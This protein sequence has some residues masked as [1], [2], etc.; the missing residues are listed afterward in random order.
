MSGKTI[1][2]IGHSTHPLEEFISMLQSFQVE[3]VADIRR[4]PG[5]KRYPYFNT[6]ALRVSLPAEGIGYTHLEDLGGRRPALPDSKNR[7]GG[8]PLFAG[9][10]IIWKHR[11]F[12][13]PLN[14]WRN[15]RP[16]N[17]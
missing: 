2:T 11:L 4:Y 16:P 15:W 10:L 1:W 12:A 14:C 3:L 6:E 13:K 7:A 9:M 5:S 8:M 17:G